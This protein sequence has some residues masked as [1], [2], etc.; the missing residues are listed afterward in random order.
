[1]RIWAGDQCL[2]GSHSL[3][4]PDEDRFFVAC[5]PHAGILAGAGT[6]QTTDEREG[7]VPDNDADCIGVSVVGHLGKEVWNIDT[8]RATL[9]TGCD[10][11]NVACL[12]GAAT[13]LDMVPPDAFMVFK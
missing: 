11:R 3:H 6:D 5:T 12:R 13:L 2:F 10:V 8:C 7:I 4:L 1:M 9:S